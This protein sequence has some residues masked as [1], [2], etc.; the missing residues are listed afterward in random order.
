M[1]AFVA[2][3]PVD[4]CASASFGDATWAERRTLSAATEATIGDACA[5][6]ACRDALTVVRA[7]L[8]AVPGAACHF[9]RAASG[10]PPVLRDERRG[11]RVVGA[12]M[13][14]CGVVLSDVRPASRR[15]RDVMR[16]CAGAS[17]VDEPASYD[18]A[19]AS[20]RDRAAS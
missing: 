7:A 13:P 10:N 8:R 1:R 11:S 17:S 12:T 18:K 2:V 19:D 20:C 4:E 3:A 14:A 6:R 5:Q 16:Q 9:G 15:A